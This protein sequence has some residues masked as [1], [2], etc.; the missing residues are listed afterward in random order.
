MEKYGSARQATDDN[1]IEYMCCACWIPKATD[2][3][4]NM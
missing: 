1:M 3:T 4:Q 2:D